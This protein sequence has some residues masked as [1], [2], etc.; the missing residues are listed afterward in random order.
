MKKALVFEASREGYG[1]DQLR[2]EVT[3][4]ELKAML[5]DM[6]DDMMFVLSH[7]N[8]YTYG[9]LSLLASI[10]EEVEGEY[11]TEY[12]EIDSTGFWNH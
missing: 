8:G 7:D 10:L 9:S 6:D 12:E 3:V 5:A 4:G 1:I 2:N 11:G